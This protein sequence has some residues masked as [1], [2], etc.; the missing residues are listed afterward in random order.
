[1]KKRF[2][3][4]SNS[5][6]ASFIVHTR[7]RPDELR[8]ILEDEG[9]INLEIGE[10]GLGNGCFGGHTWM[11]NGEEDMGEDLVK[12]VTYLRKNYHKSVMVSVDSEG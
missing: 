7:F 11:W 8:E 6:S 3:F 4:V 10:D 5:S 2:G 1:M 9:F 12:I